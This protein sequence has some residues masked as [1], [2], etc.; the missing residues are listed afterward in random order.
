MKIYQLSHHEVLM[1]ETALN[2]ERFIEQYKN[3]LDDQLR[4]HTLSTAKIFQCINIC[5]GT[6]TSNPLITEALLRKHRLPAFKF[7][8]CKN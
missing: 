1:N 2:E 7:L 8:V 4:F 6:I 3:L 5:S